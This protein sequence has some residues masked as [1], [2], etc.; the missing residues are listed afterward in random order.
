MYN[1]TKVLSGVAL[2]AVVGTTPEVNVEGME[3]GSIHIPTGSPITTLT[4]H[5]APESNGT[6]VPLKTQGNVA[7]TMTVAAGGTHPLPPECF[8]GNKVFKIV[9]NL[10]G[11]VNINL[12]D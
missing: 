4:F 3:R 8:H 1:I 9:A 6:Y 5:A 10:A 7:V 2:T 12:R 11:S